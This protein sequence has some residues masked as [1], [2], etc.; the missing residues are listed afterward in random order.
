M[1]ECEKCGGNLKYIL[2][3]MGYKCEKCGSWYFIV[4]TM[5]KD[6]EIRKIK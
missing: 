6:P 5:I 4:R 3:R 1:K 2:K